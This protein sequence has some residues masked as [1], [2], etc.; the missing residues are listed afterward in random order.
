MDSVHEAEAGV[1]YPHDKMGEEQ[2]MFL[3]LAQFVAKD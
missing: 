1:I 2:L 3:F